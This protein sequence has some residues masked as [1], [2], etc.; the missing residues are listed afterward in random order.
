M[1][2]AAISGHTRALGAPPDWDAEQYGTCGVLI[3]RDEKTDG[4]HTMASLWYPDP[5]EFELLQ[6]GAPI[7]LRVVGAVHPPVMLSVGDDP[8]S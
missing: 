5:R 2:P 7:V 4:L 8:S 3:I 1:T 6:A